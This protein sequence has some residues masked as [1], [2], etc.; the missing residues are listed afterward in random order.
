MA[1]NL[2]VFRRTIVQHALGYP[3]TVEE[4]PWGERVVK[5]NKKVFLFASNYQGRCSL[6]LKLPH[7]GASALERPEAAPMAY[8][9]G[10]HGWVTLKYDAD[11]TPPTDLLLDWMHESFCA[12]A[13]KKL[14][15]A[16]GDVRPDPAPIPGPIAFPD[17]PP[18]ILL[19]GDDEC[20]LER[21]QRGLADKG[22]HAAAVGIGEDALNATGDLGP[23]AIVV[24]LS[25]NASDALKLVPELA[26]LAHDAR[27]I[28]AG[29][30]D[31]KQE[32]VAQDA[33][34]QAVMWSREAPGDEVVLQAVTG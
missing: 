10:K 26:M 32:G 13:P 5:V 15:A 19:V 14:A 7:S 24:D 34:P 20:R 3:D 31:K 29:V 23:D 18:T 9:M 27:L 30:R 28:I 21:A 8:G 12:V 17:G 4:A 6:G 1:I 25:R 11:S 2:D 16:V 33:A 22:H